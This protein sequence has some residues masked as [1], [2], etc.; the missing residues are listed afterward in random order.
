MSMVDGMTPRYCAPEV[1]LGGDRNTKSDI[2][3]LGVVFMEMVA[4][5]KGLTTQYMDSFY[6]QH[7][8]WQAYIRSQPVGTLDIV[9]EL[10]SIGELSDNKPLRWTQKMLSE[11]RH[12][13]PTASSLVE[14]ITKLGQEGIGTGFCGLCC[15]PAG[16]NHSDWESDRS[17]T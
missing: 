4:V 16:D 14:E 2:W 6:K 17:H 3:S 5:R 13:R 12:Q 8:S 10:E 15:D 9:A 1:A 11:E 7:I